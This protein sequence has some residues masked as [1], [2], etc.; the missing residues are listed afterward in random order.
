MQYLYIFAAI[1]CIKGQCQYAADVYK[2]INNTKADYSRLHSFTTSLLS[3]VENI[4][5]TISKNIYQTTVL[6]NAR[7]VSIKD[8]YFARKS[9]NLPFTQMERSQARAYVYLI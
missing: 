7:R 8:R 1:R 4:V 5:V 6:Y 3:F 2:P 9:R